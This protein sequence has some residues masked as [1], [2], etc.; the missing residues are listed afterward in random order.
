MN[1]TWATTRERR[2][3]RAPRPPLVERPSSAQ[4]Q[5]EVGAEDARERHE[6]HPHA[7]RRRQEDDEQHHRAVD[8]DPG[9]VGQVLEVEGAERPQGDRPEGEPQRRG[10]QGQHD[11]LHDE[12]AP[13]L[14]APRAEGQPG[15][16]LLEA[17]ARPHERE[18]RDVDAADEQDEERSPPQQVEGRPDVSHQVVLQAHDA[19]VEAGVLQD[20]PELREA[21]HVRGVE[22]VHLRL[23][24]LQRRPGSQAPDVPVACSSDAARRT[25]PGA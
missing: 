13:D 10:E 23:G 21:L 7:D 17:G 5:G 19:G 20:L 3:A 9:P 11:A 16:E 15:D 6:P 24:L 22:G 25:C 4:D 14:G 8:A 2:S 1:A 12:L 18:V